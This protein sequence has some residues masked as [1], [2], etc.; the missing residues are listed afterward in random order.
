[1]W[2]LL[3]RRLKFLSGKVLFFWA[4]ASATIRVSEGISGGSRQG[5]RSRAHSA[6]LIVQH[7]KRVW[8]VEGW[9]EMDLRVE[10]RAGQR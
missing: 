4:P 10:S 2:L 9:I 1:M 3:P 7:S 8:T 5:E 6:A